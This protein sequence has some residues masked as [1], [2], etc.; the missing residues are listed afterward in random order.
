M[1]RIANTRTGRNRRT[2]RRQCFGQSFC[3]R[4][5]I[6]HLIAMLFY[7]ITSS[8]K[9]RQKQ[10]RILLMIIWVVIQWLIQIIS[11]WLSVQTLIVCYMTDNQPNNQHFSHQSIY[12]TK[13][14]ISL[15]IKSYSLWLTAQGTAIKSYD[16][17][18]MA[19]PLNVLYYMRTVSH[20][21]A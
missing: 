4:H 16:S 6:C 12:C 10:Y 14:I 3:I 20:I 8:L 7:A 5:T 21:F 17:N 13:H 19:I 9:L 18:D 15:Y 1:S 11:K 2:G